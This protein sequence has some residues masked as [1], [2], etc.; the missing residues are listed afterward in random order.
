MSGPDSIPGGSGMVAGRRID[1]S[2]RERA[3]ESQARVPTLPVEAEEPGDH[4]APRQREPATGHF[5]ERAPID[6]PGSFNL[7]GY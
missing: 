6:R 2:Q 1:K 5:T 3:S 7:R 4:P